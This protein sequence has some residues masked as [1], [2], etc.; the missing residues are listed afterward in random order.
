MT[1]LNVRHVG[2][3]TKDLNKSLKFYRDVLGFKVV[4]KMRETDRSLS[5]L[6]GLKKVQ[7]TTVKMRSKESGMLELLSWH[8]QN[9]VEK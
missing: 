9:Q 2:V 1:A 5:D 7:V 8:C 6:M 3:V 4:K